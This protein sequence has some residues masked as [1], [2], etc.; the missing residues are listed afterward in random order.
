MYPLVNITMGIMELKKMATS[1][2]KNV[3][4]G[5]TSDST[6]RKNPYSPHDLPDHQKQVSRQTKPRKFSY[7]ADE[8]DKS[9]INDTNVEQILAKNP[10]PSINIQELVCGELRDDSFINKLVPKICE[11]VCQKLEEKYV[12]LVN[13]VV[14][15]LQETVNK[16][17][18]L[19]KQQRTTIDKH[20]E[21]LPQPEHTIH[22]QDE[23]IK[24][25]QETVTDLKGNITDLQNNI[26]DL[27]MRL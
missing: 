9:G 18:E 4:T 13:D 12:T 14:K 21:K 2:I 27:H 23:H 7:S 5:E 1:K 10:E 15:P 11:S 8:L 17:A 16:E 20:V 22:K 24:T 25:L 6:K 26:S 19:I 3:N